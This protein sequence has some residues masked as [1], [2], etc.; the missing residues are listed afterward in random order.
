MMTFGWLNRLTVEGTLSSSRSTAYRQGTSLHRLALGIEFLL[1]CVMLHVHP[2][3]L[4]L[5]SLYAMRFP[6]S[7]I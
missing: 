1:S 5:S 4:L 7:V 3:N 6:Y 2:L